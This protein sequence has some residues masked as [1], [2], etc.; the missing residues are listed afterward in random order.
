MRR[1]LF[2]ILLNSLVAASAA[3]DRAGT[4]RA[5]AAPADIQLANQKIASAI[6]SGSMDSPGRVVVVYFTPNDRPPAKD[7]VER[8]RRIVEETA[9]FYDRE[10][11]RHG[12]AD[13][14]LRVYRNAQKQVEVIDVVGA[15][16]DAD[17]GKPDGNKIRQEAVAVLRTK[18]IDPEAAVLLIFCN[19]MDYNAQRGTIAHH[20]PYYGGGTYLQG[21]AWQCDSEILDPQR[22]QDATPLQ[23]GEYGRIT[24]GKHNSIFIGGV[25]HELGHALSLPHCRQRE[26]ETIYGTAL[27]GSGNRTYA[28]QLRGEGRGTFLTQVHAMRLAAH[29]VLN[30]QVPSSLFDHPDVQW[31]EL[32]VEVAANKSICVQGS[33]VASIPIHSVIAYFDAAG[34][35]DYDA[36]TAAAVPNEVGEFSLV[37]GPLRPG[38]SGQVRLLGCYVNGSTTSCELNYRVDDDG[39]PDLS[40]IHLALRLAPMLQTLRLGM[41]PEAKIELEHIA[42]GDAVLRETGIRVLN[43]FVESWQPNV[44]PRQELLN[45]IPVTVRSMALSHV[46]PRAESVGWIRPT[47]DGVPDAECLLS[48][49]GDYFAQG[50]YA[51]APAKHEYPLAGKWI[52]LKG[53][54]GVQSGHSGNVNFEIFGDSK[55]LWRKQDVS[56][57]ESAEFAIDLTGVDILKLLVTDG[58]DGTAGDW[59]VWIEPTLIR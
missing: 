17:Y 49:D 55:S 23:D 3:Q 31:R 25:I 57:G 14:H 20:S 26:D 24:I 27:M 53:R 19:L 32:R 8:I 10:L 28:E 7:H 11:A 52:Q 6:G 45:Q 5:F 15:G 41:L 34:G 18:Q 13:R 42:S 37:S 2:F 54:C 9:G 35:G 33:I 21:T 50:I 40:A 12:F 36:T 4:D 22:F 39:N 30:A 59:G 38:V 48:I 1:I 44:K 43:R 16:P 58:G 46:Q 51:H 29:P 47:Y 56:D